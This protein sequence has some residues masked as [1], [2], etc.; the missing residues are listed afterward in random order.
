MC[1]PLS[2]APASDP[3][4]LDLRPLSCRADQVPM[5]EENSAR[6][7]QAMKHH[8]Q[9]TDHISFECST[10]TGAITCAILPHVA[11]INPIERVKLGAAHSPSTLINEENRTLRLKQT[12]SHKIT[13][14]TPRCKTCLTA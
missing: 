1:T 11:A 13:A 10:L 7:E 4:K 9:E 5:V 14:P 6:L 2:G 12:S 8:L 3:E